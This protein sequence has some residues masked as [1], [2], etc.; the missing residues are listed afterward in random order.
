[1]IDDLLPYFVPWILFAWATYNWACQGIRADELQRKLDDE[2]MDNLDLAEKAAKYDE[3]K[4]RI[5]LRRK[6]RGF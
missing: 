2:H 1:V 5:R 3:I 6:E 4:R